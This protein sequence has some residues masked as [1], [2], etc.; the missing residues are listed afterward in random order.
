MKLYLVRHA[1]AE[2]R[3]T[4]AQT[5]QP[6]H[7]RPLTDKGIQ[8]MKDVLNFF[9]RSESHLD[10]VLQSPF[11]RCQQTGDIFKEYYPGANYITTDNLTPDHS[12]KKLFEEIQSHN[13]DA[14]AVIGHEPDMGMFLSWLLFHQATDHFPF[15]KSG[16]AKV[17]LYKDGRSYLKWLV[18]PKMA[19]I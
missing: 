8:R 11:T 2:Y 15:K 7:L 10:V 5:G 3:H 19:Q 13:V 17:D 12:A 18:R 9:Q 1:P 16:I 4:F 6:D 14:M